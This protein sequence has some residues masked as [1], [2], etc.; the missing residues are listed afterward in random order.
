[1]DMLRTIREAIDGVPAAQLGTLADLTG[2]SVNTI[3]KLRNGQ[4]A[5]PR[6]STAEPLYLA[7]VHGQWLRSGR[8][9]SRSNAA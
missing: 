2:V 4:T 9:S 8:S 7:I 6:I 1:M 3:I 5:D